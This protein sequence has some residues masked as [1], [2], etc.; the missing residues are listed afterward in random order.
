MAEGAL[1]LVLALA[2]P[3]VAAKCHLKGVM[4]DEEI[5]ACRA[6]ERASAQPKPAEPRPGFGPAL[7]E[8]APS[9]RHASGPESAEQR[10]QRANDPAYG[11]S[12]RVEAAA[13]TNVVVEQVSTGA[14]TVT[15]TGTGDDGPVA[16]YLRNLEQAGMRGFLQGM[17]DREDGQ[18]E[19]T[20]VVHAD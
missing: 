17:R 12:R 2:A 6:D 18:Q 3:A 8:P 11:L 7:K 20:L 19:F 14:D 5:A 1:A 15:V 13:P 10:L 4:T 16:T 9:Q